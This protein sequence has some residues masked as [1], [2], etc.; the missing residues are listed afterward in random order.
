MKSRA[1]LVLYLCLGLAVSRNSFAQAPRPIT[2]DG[3][4]QT[5][6]T[7][8]GN[9]TG[10]TTNTIRGANAFNSFTTF[11]VGKGT[12]ANLYLP[13]A[14][15]NLLNLVNGSAS[16]IDGILNSIKNGQIGGHVFFINPYG[17]VV[18]STG[19]VNVGAL[20]VITPTKGFMNSFFDGTGNISAAA[21]AS[22]LTGNVPLSSD[23]LISVRGRINAIGDIRLAGGDVVNSGVIGTG[24]VFVARRPDF[25][26]VVNIKGLQG[27]SQITVANGNIEIVAAHDVENSGIISA[28]GVPGVNGGNISVQAGNDIRLIGNSVI[29]SSGGGNNSSAGNIKILADNNAYLIDHAQVA[30]NGGSIS[31][32]AGSIEFSA[33]GTLTINGGNLSAAAVNG[34]PGHILLDPT[35]LVINTSENSGGADITLSA[36]NSITVGCAAAGCNQGSSVV[37][38]SSQNLDGSGN[39]KGNSGNISLTAPQI[40]LLDNSQLIAAANNGNTAG[41]INLTA[42]ASSGV[43][44]SNA[45]ASITVGKATLNGGDISL[46]ASATGNGAIT[47][48]NAGITIGD[49]A[50]AA[51]LIGHDITLSA[52]ATAKADNTASGM[53]QNNPVTSKY[54]DNPVEASANISNAT[55]N[56]DISN[57]NITA[58]DKVSIASDANSTTKI[59][60]G[61]LILVTQNGGSAAGFLYGESN[62]NSTVKLESGAKI[63]ASGAFSLTA[64]AEN[65]L[66]ISANATDN[67]QSTAAFAF[68]KAAS[69]SAVQ[70]DGSVSAGNGITAASTITNNFS[71]V[72]NGADYKASGGAGIALAIADY[73]SSATNNVTGTLAASAGD[74]DVSASS[75]NAQNFTNAQSQVDAGTNTETT[76][77]NGAQSG[78]STKIFSQAPQPP[79][80][81]NSGPLGVAGAMAFVDSSNSAGTTVSG[82]VTASQ[83]A[84]KVTSTATDQPGVS[85]AGSSAGQ[86]TNI[87]GALALGTFSNAANTVVNGNAVLAGNTGVQVTADAE[88]INPVVPLIDSAIQPFKGDPNIDW[89]DKSKWQ[90]NLWGE[91]QDLKAL[92]ENAKNAL[93]NPGTIT[94]SFVNTGTSAGKSSGDTSIGIAGSIDITSLSNSAIATVQDYA[95]LTAATG[96]VAVTGTANA[97]M[98]NLSGMVFSTSQ[99]KSRNPGVQGDGSLGGSISA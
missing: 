21:T 11:N 16:T 14:T 20:T 49:S 13:S 52:T 5:S 10:I 67:S 41:N 65:T 2:P 50:G 30:A 53:A 3:R 45:N 47:S 17:M 7:V 94:T 89:S 80:E 63:T 79:A 83:G 93:T 90:S 97:N 72:A 69:A 58:S 92:G 62:A 24:A 15:N 35:D 18:G 8:N 46:T 66:D 19:V 25:A 43:L 36:D 88:L 70:I 6:V 95:Q 86:D 61:P 31:G 76:I 40:S 57:A 71:T 27:G 98:V 81:S 1:L 87:G 99:L 29:A 4:T 42:T 48:A 55:A 75:T 33:K 37:T 91:I 28:T 59:S 26:D 68:G 84:V 32:D 56:I 60:S 23:G 78:I 73:Q 51:T 85:A 77:L 12:T 39:S 54:F 74:I 9:V 22:V 38:V 34:A 82:T 44:S 96:D 64:S